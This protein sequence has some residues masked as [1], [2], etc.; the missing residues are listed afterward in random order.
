MFKAILI[1]FLPIISAALLPIVTTTINVTQ[2]F[3][4]MPKPDPVPSIRFTFYRAP[5]GARL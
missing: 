3:I 4:P 2:T 5:D 1:A